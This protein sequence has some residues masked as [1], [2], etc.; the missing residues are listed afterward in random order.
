MTVFY[1]LLGIAI[2]WEK[3]KPIFVMGFEK[4]CLRGANPILRVASISAFLKSEQIWIM[5]S[6]NLFLRRNGKL[7]NIET[8]KA[9]K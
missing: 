3:L 2:Y 5:G 4:S 7:Y 9:L 8:E 6:T 1:I